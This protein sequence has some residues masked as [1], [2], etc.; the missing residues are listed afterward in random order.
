MKEVSWG[1]AMLPLRHGLKLPNGAMAMMPGYL[2]DSACFGIKLVSLFPENA[3]VG[4]PSRLLP[5]ATAIAGEARLAGP[6]L[7]GQGRINRP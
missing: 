6:S 7:T 2:G 4:L 3:A 5:R 1:S